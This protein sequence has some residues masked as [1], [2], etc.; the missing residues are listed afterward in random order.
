MRD[1][2]QYAVRGVISGLHDLGVAKSESLFI[3]EPTGAFQSHPALSGTSDYDSTKLFDKITDWHLATLILNIRFL[4]S[5]FL[6]L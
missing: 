5:S 3:L 4:F 6:V 2:L 1:N